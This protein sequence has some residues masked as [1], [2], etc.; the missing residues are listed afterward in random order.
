MKVIRKCVS[1]LHEY[2]EPFCSLY[3]WEPYGPSKVAKNQLIYDMALVWASVCITYVYRTLVLSLNI[4]FGYKYGAKKADILSILIITVTAVLP[5][6]PYVRWVGI[7]PVNSATEWVRAV[8]MTRSA[9]LAAHKLSYNTDNEL[10]FHLQY[11]KHRH[12]APRGEPGDQFAL[13]IIIKQLI[14]WLETNRHRFFILFNNVPEQSSRH[15]YD[16]ECNHYWFD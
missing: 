9:H 5:I 3:H 10:I 8:C 15:V 1:I 14:N 4:W 12:M 13:D 7:R 6:Q 11:G 2:K 16:I